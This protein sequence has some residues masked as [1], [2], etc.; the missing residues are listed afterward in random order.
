LRGGGRLAAAPGTAAGAR[1]VA[2]VVDRARIAVVAG[3]AGVHLVPAGAVHARAAGE[4]PRR[5]VARHPGAGRGQAHAVAAAVDAA[6]RLRRVLARAR[7]AGA[8]R[9][10]GLEGVRA[11]AAAGRRREARARRARAAARDALVAVGAR[12]AV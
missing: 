10:E 7:D 4:A 12:V 2:R 9:R 5:H 6:A 11:G 1:G 3:G 8:R